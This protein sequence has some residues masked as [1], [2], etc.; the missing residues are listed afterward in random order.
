LVELLIAMGVF[1]LATSTITFLIIDA[2]IANRAGRERTMA[3][4]LAEEGIEASRSI[5]DNNWGN[6]AAGEHGLAIS[7]GN[8]IFS[9]TQDDISNQ[10]KEGSRKI[11]V[12]NIDSKRKK[13]TSQVTWKLTEA[14]S[15]AV[16]LITYLTNWGL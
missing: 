16:N 9:G 12:E 11:T 13:I 1:V 6:L 10:L 8:W 14:R 2:Y 7:G 4:F 15:Q 5:R 3:T